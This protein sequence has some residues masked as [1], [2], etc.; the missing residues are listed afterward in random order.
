MK[1]KQSITL[2][3]YPKFT[4]LIASLV[5]ADYTRVPMVMDP[6]EFSVRGDII[7]L[8]STNFL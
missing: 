8:F 3:K 4:T 2:K 1:Q 5:K 6:G 7:D